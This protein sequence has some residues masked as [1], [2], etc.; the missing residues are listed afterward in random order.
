MLYILIS[1]ELKPSY[2]SINNQYGRPYAASRVEAKL[3]ENRHHQTHGCKSMLNYIPQ[4]NPNYAANNKHMLM[5]HHATSILFLVPIVAKLIW[6]ERKC[7]AALSSNKGH[8]EHLQLMCCVTFTIDLTISTLS[9]PLT[10]TSL[11]TST[12]AVE[13]VDTQQKVTQLQ[14]SQSFKQ[15]MWWNNL[16]FINS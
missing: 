4:Q 7:K 5:V 2:N 15:W 11:D 10:R 16:Y 6:P 12:T 9:S 3:F 1:L 13:K 8:Y 14:S